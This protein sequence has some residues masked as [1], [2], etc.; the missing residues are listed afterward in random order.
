MW[1]V[2]FFFFNLFLRSFVASCRL[3]AL[4]SQWCSSTAEGGGG[5]GGLRSNCPTLAGR[6]SAAMLWLVCFSSSCST[7]AAGG[8]KSEESETFQ[9]F[10]VPWDCY[11]HRHGLA[12][13]SR[14]VSRL[15]AS[16]SPSLKGPLTP[17]LDSRGGGHHGWS[18]W[19]G[20]PRPYG[21]MKQPVK[22]SL[23]GGVCAPWPPRRDCMRCGCSTAPRWV[24][25]P[26]SH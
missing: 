13:A 20:E 14:K 18:C 10:I 6:N 12:A 11:M 16:D 17:R 9:H 5:A 25:L 22:W 15:R 24:R 4:E 19:G 7:G 1:C 8:G 2:F 21:A 23:V 3:S 26:Q